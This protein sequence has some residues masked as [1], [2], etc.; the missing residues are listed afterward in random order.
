LNPCFFGIDKYRL[1]ER[2][3]EFANLADA[4]LD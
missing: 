2:M 3:R 1:V 4:A